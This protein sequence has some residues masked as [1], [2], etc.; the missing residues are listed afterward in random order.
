M[1]FRTL[2]AALTL[3][4]ALLVNFGCAEAQRMTRTATDAAGSLAGTVSASWE[5]NPATYRGQIG[6]R[7]AYVCSPNG[8]TGSVWGTDAYSDDSSVCTAGVHAG[9]ITLSQGGRVVIEI[10]GGRSSYVGSTRHGITSY[11]WGS[12]PGSFAVVNA[13][14]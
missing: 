12:W 6:A 9:A 14:H 5:Q 8:A 4:A 2:T 11:E 13:M 1:R 7:Y 10:Q 3:G